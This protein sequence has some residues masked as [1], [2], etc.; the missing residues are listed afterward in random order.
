M[1]PSDVREIRGAILIGASRSRSRA[2][3][4]RPSI[5]T[6]LSPTMMAAAITMPAIH[7][8][9]RLIVTDLLS[10]GEDLLPALAAFL[11]REEADAARRLRASPVPR[12]C[13]VTH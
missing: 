2:I 7:F 6:K 12:A 9:V 4:S 11:C 13:G 10:S 5:N 3:S 1:S 8:T